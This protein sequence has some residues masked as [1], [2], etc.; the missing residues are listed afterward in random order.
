M[1][2]K[3]IKVV[4][5]FCGIGGLSNGF[6]QEGFDVV[7]GYDNDK[8]CKFAYKVNNHAKF[9]LANITKVTGKE[10]NQ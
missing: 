5:L 8:S 7:A 2:K 3:R 1:I 9:H 4:D 6:F 10:I